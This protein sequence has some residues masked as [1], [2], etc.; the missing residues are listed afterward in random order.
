MALFRIDA[1][2]FIERGTNNVV[3]NFDEY[4]F[5]G[6]EVSMRWSP[7]TDLRLLAGYTYMDSKNMEPNGGTDRLQNRPEHK[8]TLTADYYVGYGVSLNAQYLYVAGSYALERTGGNAVPV[9]TLE[10]DDYHLINVGATYDLLPEGAAQIYAR[11]ENLLDEDYE[12][13]FG[14]PQAGLS[15]WIGLRARW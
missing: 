1:E 12:D 14:F 11:G 4:R 2:D 6:V 3:Q 10:L 5:Q 13:S 8:A 7:I 9:Q 15:G